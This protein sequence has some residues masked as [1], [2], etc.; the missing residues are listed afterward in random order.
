[1]LYYQVVNN[2]HQDG[3]DYPRKRRWVWDIDDVACQ[4]D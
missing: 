1:M 4:L 2:Y 3:S